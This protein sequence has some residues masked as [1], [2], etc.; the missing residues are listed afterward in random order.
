[1]KKSISIMAMIVIGIAGTSLS[2]CSSQKPEQ[3]NRILRIDGDKPTSLAE[4]LSAV[5]GRT[6]MKVESQDFDFGG[7]SGT[8]KSVLIYDSRTSVMVRGTSTEEC[9]PMEGRRDPSFSPTIFGVSIYRTSVFKPRMALA[10]VAKVLDEEARKRGGE[11][12]TESQ[13]CEDRAAL[14]FQSGRNSP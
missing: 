10:E 14:H 1:M 12:I 4:I 5:A 2:S 9:R 7:K 11:L 8:L 6:N 13:K 3:I